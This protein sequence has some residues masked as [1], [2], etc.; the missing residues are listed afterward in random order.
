VIHLRGYIGAYPLTVNSM[1]PYARPSRAIAV[2][3]FPYL[4][5]IL[6]TYLL[7]YHRAN[8]RR[9]TKKPTQLPIELVDHIVQEILLSSYAELPRGEGRRAA[10]PA[11]SSVTLTN[12]VFRE[13]ALRAWFSTFHV[14]TFGDFGYLGKR[15]GTESQYLSAV[16]YVFFVFLLYARLK[17]TC[18]RLGLFNFTSRFP[19]DRHFRYHI[20]LPFSR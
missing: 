5:D 9:I 2:F 6:A 7:P 11:I 3:P 10:W 20:F 15:I 19:V 8:N 13:V 1:A 18:A 12:S 14:Q 17:L 4:S 16:R